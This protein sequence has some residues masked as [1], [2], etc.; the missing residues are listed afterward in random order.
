MFMGIENLDRRTICTVGCVAF[1]NLQ[2][3]IEHL[4]ATHHAMYRSTV[5]CVALD[6]L[7]LKSNIS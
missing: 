4:I 2:L 5:G 3:P 6:N 7:Q 1:N